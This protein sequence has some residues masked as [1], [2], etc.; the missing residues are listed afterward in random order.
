LATFEAFQAEVPSAAPGRAVKR[1]VAIEAP[2]TGFAEQ[3]DSVSGWR[4]SRPFKISVGRRKKKRQSAITPGGLRACLS[5]GVVSALASLLPGKSTFVS[6]RSFR[7]VTPLDVAPPIGGQTLPIH[8][9]Y[10]GAGKPANNRQVSGPKH[11]KD[12]H[13]GAI[14]LADWGI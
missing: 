14:N 6:G 4:A 13:P 5:P 9:I 12:S 10:Q 3:H 8:R 7:G 2:F 11:V 1:S